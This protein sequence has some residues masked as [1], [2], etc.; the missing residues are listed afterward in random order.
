MVNQASMGRDEDLYAILGVSPSADAET[1]ERAFR[2]QIKQTHP[3]LAKNKADEL[4]R[5]AAASRLNQAADI[6]RD[7]ARRAAYDLDRAAARAAAYVAAR[8][9]T[10]PGPKP[11]ASGPG[12]A[13]RAAPGSPSRP[14]PNIPRF[15]FFRRRAVHSR[16]D[17]FRYTRLG[18]WL[19][20][21]VVVV[22]AGI[23]SSFVSPADAGLFT[24]RVA[25]VWLVIG[26]LA[27]RNLANPAG[28]LLRAGFRALDWLMDRWREQFMAKAN[29]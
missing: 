13:W 24:V 28:D 26:N 12:S 1:I 5:T 17:W 15:E 2:D 4:G 7:P 8:P 23:I 29:H 11:Q 6:L 10:T 16:T 19:A 25:L 22:G 18:Q 3:D 27:T 14:D 20:L 21:I 9:A